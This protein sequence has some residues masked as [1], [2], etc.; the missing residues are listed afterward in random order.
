MAATVEE[1]FRV[2]LSRLTPTGTETAAAKSHR[3]TIEACLKNNFEITRFFRAGSFGNGTSIRNHSDVDYL[4]SIPSKYITVNSNST[5]QKVWKALDARFPNSGIGIRGPAIMIPFG[6]NG[7]E[8]T[9]VVPAHL[10]DSD[11]DK[12]P[13]Y[14]IP[15]RAGGWMRTS[16]DAHNAYVAN[17][18]RKLNGKVKPLIRFIKAWKYFRNAPLYSFYLEMITTR[19]ASKEPM[20]VYSIDMNKIFRILW[21]DQLARMQDPIGISGYISPCFSEAMR[22]DALSKVHTAL[23]RVEKAWDAESAKNTKDAFY[24]WNLVLDGFPAYG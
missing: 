18:D 7:S 8:S 24:W 20:I 17:V 11:K 9:D 3:A 5:L 13:I 22:Q 2:L 10:V 15:D 1:G 16:P 14:E 6:P 21:N 4:A 23:S 12:N 19:Y